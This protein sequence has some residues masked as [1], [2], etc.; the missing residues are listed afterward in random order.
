[1]GADVSGGLTDVGVDSAGGVSASDIEV[2]ACFVGVNATANDPSLAL[3]N[4][5]D[6]QMI[7]SVSAPSAAIRTGNFFF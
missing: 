2:A 1:M 5:H 3:M 4:Q 6:P 7:K